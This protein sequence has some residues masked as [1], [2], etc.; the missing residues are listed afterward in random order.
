MLWYLQGTME[1]E[2]MY[3]AGASIES[4]DYR[5]ARHLTCP[6]TSQVRVGFV[7]LSAREASLWAMHPSAHVRVS[8]WLLPWPA[9]K[10]IF[11]DN[12][13]PRWM[14]REHKCVHWF[15]L[16]IVSLLSTR[17]TIRSTRLALNMPR[18]STYS[19]GIVFTMSVSDIVASQH[20]RTSF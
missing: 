20:T 10:P 11:T 9:K 12:S 14:Q 3:H 16:S 8:I 4:W 1:E 6:N 18:P 7:F 5:D 17:P 19:S 13:S 15:C 2:I